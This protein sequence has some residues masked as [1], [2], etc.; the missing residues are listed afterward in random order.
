MTDEDGQDAGTFLFRKPVGTGREPMAHRIVQTVEFIED[1]KDDVK[2]IVQ[3]HRD[4][5]A[6]MRGYKRAITVGGIVAAAVVIIA[7]YW[8]AI[9]VAWGIAMGNP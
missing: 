9:T 7:Q 8:P 2:T 3:R 4:S 5:A 6:L 1:N